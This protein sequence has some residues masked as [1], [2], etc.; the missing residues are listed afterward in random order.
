M[1]PLVS[2]VIPCRNAEAWLAD[3]VDSCLAQTWRNLE[4]IVIDDGSTD[5]SLEIARRYEPRGVFVLECA[6]Q[7]ASAARNLGLTHARGDLIQ[8]LDADDVLD[9]EKIR[10]QVERLASAPAASI[11]SGA[12]ARFRRSPSEATFTV[13]PVWRDL[14]PEEFLIRSWLGGGMM[15]SF[16]WLTPRALIERA[17]PWNESLSLDDDGEFFSRVLLAASGIVFCPQARGFYR[18]GLDA[19]MSRQSGSHAL[20]SAFAATE[21]S[22]GYLLQRCKSEAAHK[23]CATHYQ[24]L[25]YAAYPQ[26][27][28]LVAQAEMRIRELGGSELDP[29]GGA[30]FRLLARSF[31]WKFAKRCQSAWH[32]RSHEVAASP[33]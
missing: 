10:V 16:A 29:G 12:W 18:S 13:E 23:A 32:K 28:E 14:A 24:R 19:S 15:A 31:G 25:V 1:S 20:A 27:P 4:I 33:Q 22:R 2:V 7:G 8:F 17:G 26:A 9:A 30:A 3:A 6:R 21:L 11:A 5:R